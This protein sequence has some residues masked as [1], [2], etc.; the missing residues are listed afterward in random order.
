ME[1]RQLTY[2]EAVVRCGGFTRAAEDLHIAQPAISAQIRRLETEL[3]V[4][5]LARTS[6]RV[7][8]TEAG[9]LFLAR[10]RRIQGEIT[11]A[12]EEIDDVGAVQRGR[13]VLGATGVLGGFDLP[14]ALAGFAQRFP[15]VTLSLR[16]GLVGP[17]LDELADGTVDLVLGPVH[18]DLPAGVVA[19]PLVSDRLVLLTAPGRLPRGNPVGIADVADEPFVCLPEGSGL[20]D[21]LDRMAADAGLASPVRFE[22]AT[23][24]G[25]RALVAAG[26][27][28]ALLAASAAGTPGPPVDAH[29]VSPP[30]SHPPFGILRPADRSPSPAAEALYRHVVRLAGHDVA[31]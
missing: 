1:L 25:V 20:R 16:S 5:L 24:A 18:A 13:V 30:T 8:L 22:A 28:V 3:G 31:D 15:G 9:E 29:E 7:A 4:P 6:R 21:L 2:F 14:A 12:R 26:L 27:G 10:V 11:A 23:P 17:L 19:R